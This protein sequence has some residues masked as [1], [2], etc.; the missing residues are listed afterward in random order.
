[1]VDWRACVDPDADNVEVDSSHVG[2]CVHAQ[3]YELLGERLAALAASA[4]SDVDVTPGADAPSRRGVTEPRAALD[5][6]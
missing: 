2:M 4:P 6:E 3:V 5:S 1:V